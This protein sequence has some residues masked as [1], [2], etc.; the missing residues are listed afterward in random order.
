MDTPFVSKMQLKKNHFFFCFI[1]KNCNFFFKIH[2]CH[3]ISG[4]KIKAKKFILGL[5]LQI[6]GWTYVSYRVAGL[7]EIKVALILS[8]VSNLFGSLKSANSVD[9]INTA[10]TFKRTEI[11]LL[12]DEKGLYKLGQLV[13]HLYFIV[14]T[15]N[16][17]HPFSEWLSYSLYK[18]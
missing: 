1:S 14:F 9:N 7:L 12:V 3:K 8:A 18:K 11:N 2:F 17:T 5:N 4:G 16:W 15:L 6:L 10:R 13:I